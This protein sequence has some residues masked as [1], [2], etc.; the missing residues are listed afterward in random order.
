LAIPSL[1]YFPKQVNQKQPK[2]TKKECNTSS[3]AVSIDTVHIFFSVHFKIYLPPEPLTC[4][5]AMMGF[6]RSPQPNDTREDS[7]RILCHEV[8]E[9][10]ACHRRSA[11][12]SA[13]KRAREEELSLAFDFGGGL[14]A[15]LTI[16]EEGQLGI[17]PCSK[18]QR[19]S[20]LISM[21]HNDSFDKVLRPVY[22]QL[23]PNITHPLAQL[24]NHTF[25]T[26]TRFDRDAFERVMRQLTLMPKIIEDAGRQKNALELVVN[27]ML[28]TYPAQS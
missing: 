6:G 27:V 13:S 8:F 15:E 21:A 5:M 18:S 23:V 2:S 4:K 11:D 1:I 12:E 9:L 7:G 25:S 14:D 22:V 20:A 19:A 24:D 10:R 16:A 17:R 26:H 28:W 3:L